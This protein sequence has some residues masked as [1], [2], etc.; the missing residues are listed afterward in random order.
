MKYK[1]FISGNTVATE[2]ATVDRV[3]DDNSSSNVV[4]SSGIP[5]NGSDNQQTSQRKQWEINEVKYMAAS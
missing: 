3:T 4:S 5:L 2:E 1:F